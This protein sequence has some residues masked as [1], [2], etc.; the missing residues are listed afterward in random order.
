MTL[1]EATQHLPQRVTARCDEC[2]T[3]REKCP[4]DDCQA[5]RLCGC[6]WDYAYFHSWSLP[7]VEFTSERRAWWS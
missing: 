7:F 4:K 2:G 1:A 3:V 6:T 5:C